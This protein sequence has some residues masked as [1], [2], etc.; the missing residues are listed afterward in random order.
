MNEPILCRNCDSSNVIETPNGILAPFFVLR[1]IGR[2][3]LHVDSV[4]E[5]LT[6]TAESTKSK[7]RRYA[8]NILLRIANRFPRLREASSAM[9]PDSQAS[10]NVLIRVCEDCTFVGPSQVYP[11]NQLIGLYR[12]YRSDS[13][14]RDRCSVEPSY[15]DIMHLVG[16][17]QEEIDSRMT[18][19]N[20]IIDSLVDCERIKTV[21]DWGGGEGRF[22]PTS[23]RSKSVTVLDYSTEEL[24][25]PSFLRLDQL[26]SDQTYDYIQVCH[27]FE[28]VSEPRSLM[29]K[30]VSHL[31]RG[32][33]VYIELPQDR[34]NEDLQNFVLS[35]FEMYHVIHEHLN[36]YSLASLDRIGLSLGL[37]CVHLD[38]CQLNIGWI[39]ATIISGLFVKDS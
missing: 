39:N 6:K 10:L 29:T 34:S 24:S 3:S 31:N 23:L 28:H 37:R 11:H 20:V 4:Y 14:N 9:R 25:D 7:S 27:V 21:L 33:Y 32:G 5:V 2:I 19:L 36:L 22:I 15:Q 12:D 1:V 8:A 13:Y 30:I 18:N 38:S 35:P 16:K 17:C 26:N